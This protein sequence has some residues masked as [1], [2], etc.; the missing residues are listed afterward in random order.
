MAAHEYHMSENR[1]RTETSVMP[2]ILDD[3]LS[4]LVQNL[5]KFPEI[6]A[7][8]N[9][10]WDVQLFCCCDAFLQKRRLARFRLRRIQNPLQ[11][12]V[13]RAM[14]LADEI[15]R[16]FESCPAF[17]FAFFVVMAP[18]RIR[19]NISASIGRAEKDPAA[20]LTDNGN[21]VVE[22]SRS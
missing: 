3:G 11:A 14:M 22:I 15:D 7:G 9:V 19:E 12:A 6:A 8:V 21:I 4:V 1:S 5:D 10:Y 17:F 16:A 20:E 18:R 13:M 2:E